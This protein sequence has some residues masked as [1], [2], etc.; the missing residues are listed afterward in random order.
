MK[1]NQASSTAFTVLQG[2]LHIA[3][4]SDHAYL[5]SKEE[6]GRAS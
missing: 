2:I 5:V 3:Q 1:D 6:V 4:S